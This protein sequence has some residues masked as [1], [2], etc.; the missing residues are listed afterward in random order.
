[1]PGGTEIPLISPLILLLTRFGG[2]GFLNNCNYRKENTAGLI[3]RL[4]RFAAKLPNLQKCHPKGVSVITLFCKYLLLF[5]LSIS[6]PNTTYQLPSI[7]ARKNN[8]TLLEILGYYEYSNRRHKKQAYPDITWYH[9]VRTIF[10][11][12]INILR[13]TGF[14][15]I[16]GDNWCLG[17]LF[18]PCRWPLT[19]LYHHAVMFL[20]HYWIQEYGP[21]AVSWVNCWV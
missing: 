20:R 1:M 8:R 12:V 16:L 17:F 5:N 4:D 2:W 7:S 10:G 3:S 14:L 13:E 19:W 11:W 15:A 18:F 9:S 21:F 6:C